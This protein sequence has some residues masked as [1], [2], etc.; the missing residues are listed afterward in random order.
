MLKT[1]SQRRAIILTLIGVVLFIG[2]ILLLLN[3]I[4]DGMDED[5]LRPLLFVIFSLFLIFAGI[6]RWIFVCKFEK[7]SDK[8]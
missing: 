3:V 8:K 6:I 1:K 5:I 7:T 4:R 2:G